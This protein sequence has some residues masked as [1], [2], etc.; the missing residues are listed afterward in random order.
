MNRD[1]TIRRVKPEDAACVAL[2]GCYRVDDAA[3]RPAY[4]AWV[5]RRIEA[6]TYLGRLAVEGGIVVSGAGAVL[7]DWGP[8]RANPGGTMARIVNVYTEHAWRRQ[9]FAKRLLEA[10]LADCEQR[11]VRE[12]NLGATEEARSLYEALGFLTYPAEMRR[13]TSGN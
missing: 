8:T 13:R 2:H 6:G 9:G 4:E 12:F 5:R 1:L 7:L 3:R 10:L 11:G